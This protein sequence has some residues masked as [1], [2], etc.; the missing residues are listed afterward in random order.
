M[1]L[2]GILMYRQ[3]LAER[4]SRDAKQSQ[5]GNG[6][7]Y[8]YQFLSGWD[9][10]AKGY[11]TVT[12]ISWCRLGA[13]SFAFGLR[14]FDRRLRCRT[15]SNSFWPSAWLVSSQHAASRK[16]PQYL[17]HLSRSRLSQCTQASTSKIVA[18]QAVPAAP[19]FLLCRTQ[20]EVCAC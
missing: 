1:P 19:N 5:S 18:G 8:G 11:R 13:S 20:R 6:A 9:S 12:V 17:S 10:L 16:K 4:P 2:G 7:L 15:A 14:Y 3:Y